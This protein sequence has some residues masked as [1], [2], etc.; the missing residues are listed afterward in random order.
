MKSPKL[1]LTDA[2]VLLLLHAIRTKLEESRSIRGGIHISIKE[3][4]ELDEEIDVL[5]SLYDKVKTYRELE[6]GRKEN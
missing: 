6:E 1:I 3:K 4:R 5:E 2:E